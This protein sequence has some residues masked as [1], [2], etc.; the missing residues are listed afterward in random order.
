VTQPSAARR[1]AGWT[2]RSARDGVTFGV[3]AAAGAG[4]AGS[5]LEEEAMTVAGAA[6]RMAHRIVASSLDSAAMAGVRLIGRRRTIRGVEQTAQ[7]LR[8]LQGHLDG[9]DY[10]LH[11]RQ[12]DADVGDDILAA[13]VRSDLGPVLRALD[14][15]RIDVAVEDGVAILHG[16][17]AD[18]GQAADITTA[19]GQ[20]PG[21]RDVDA[22]LHVGLAKG[23]T[24]PSAGRAHPSASAQLRQLQATATALGVTSDQ[25]AAVMRVFLLRLPEG[26]RAHVVG[27]LPA[28][29]REPVDRVPAPDDVLHIR[30]VDGLV[31]AVAETAGMDD[32]TALHALEAVLFML[33]EQVPEE[34]ADI[35]AVLPE[36]LRE[37]WFTATAADDDEAPQA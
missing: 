12:P 18:A 24:R 1:L 25:V 13:R 23:G 27:H 26:E 8:F 30:D 22:R 35:P 7:W 15:P 2:G 19:V 9:L 29:V 6:S 16:S 17:V 5:G 4:Q 37:L 10:R 31:A 32:R 21:I 36:E 14:L 28:D 20:I 34:S 11:G 3:G 33:A